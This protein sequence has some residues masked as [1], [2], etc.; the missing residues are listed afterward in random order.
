MTRREGR[1]A[2]AAIVALLVLGGA[3]V[4]MPFRHGVIVQVWLLGC[5]ALILLKLVVATRAPELGNE[6][7]AFERALRG[8]RPAPERPPELARLE[9]EIV[10]GVGGQFYLHRRLRQTLRE[11]AEQRLRDRRGLDL[12]RGGDDVREVLGDDAWALLRPDRKEHWDPD[13]TGIPL[14][15]LGRVVAALERI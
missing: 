9:R 7:S 12:D 10:L 8:S 3:L 5:G 14:P 11:I 6:P 13:A 2:G 1:L 15:E 4:T